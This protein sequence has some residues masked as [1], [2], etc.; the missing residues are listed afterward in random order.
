VFAQ[1]TVTVSPSVK[2]TLGLKLEHN[3]YSGWEPQPD[4]RLAWQTTDALMVWAAASRAIRAPTPFD[5][6]LLERLGGVDF[7]VGNPQFQPEKVITYEA[8][9]RASVAPT[10]VLSMSS[11]YNRYNDLRTIELSSTPTFLPLIWGNLMDGHTYGMTAWAQWQVTPRWRL[12]PGFAL[13][14]KR[15]DFKP[16]ASGLVGVGQ[17]GNDPHGHALLTSS[18]DLG[19][20]QSF[21]VSLRHVA[22]L[23]DPELPAY[24]ELSAR[25]AWR[26]SDVWELSMRGVNLLHK[27]HQ[28]YPG[29]TG[30]F[31]NRGILAEARW[32]P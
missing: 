2:L 6:D 17:S 32:R 26:I 11:F 31:I 18:L 4:A 1:D 15:L 21:D 7:L 3:S 10:F 5:V 27:R 19:R 9:F 24:T 23:P 22:R 12:A 16:G 30:T 13:L 29:G 14:E 28:E 25:Y 20:N 8:G